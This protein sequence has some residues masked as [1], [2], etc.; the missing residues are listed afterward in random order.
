MCVQLGA[1]CA[2]REYTF[3]VVMGGQASVQHRH[4]PHPANLRFADESCSSLTCTFR[5]QAARPRWATDVRCPA[6]HTRGRVPQPRALYEVIVCVS[7]S[8]SNVH[9]RAIGSSHQGPCS[10]ILNAQL[11]LRRLFTATYS[12]NQNSLFLPS[13]RSG[14]DRRMGLSW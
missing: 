12:L 5:A 8:H 11:G 2:A 13:L 6:H 1:I 10:N 7:W 14:E 3:Q 9:G 4:T